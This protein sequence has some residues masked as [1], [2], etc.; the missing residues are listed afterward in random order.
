MPSGRGVY[1]RYPDG[2]EEW[3]DRNYLVSSDLF[4]ALESDPAL[5]SF[6]WYEYFYCP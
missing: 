2:T 5:S 1:V 6:E 4:F 3:K